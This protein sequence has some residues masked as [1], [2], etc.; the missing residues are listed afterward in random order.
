MLC[1]FQWFFASYI[2][3][4]FDLKLLVIA[5]LCSPL[6]EGTKHTAFHLLNVQQKQSFCIQYI[7]GFFQ[8]E[9]GNMAGFFFLDIARWSIKVKV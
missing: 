1:L 6:L 4:L 9:S 3:R 5:G 8:R 2:I 7:E